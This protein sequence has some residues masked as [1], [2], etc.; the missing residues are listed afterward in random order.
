MGHARCLAMLKLIL[1]LF[2]LVCVFSAYFINTFSYM[3]KYHIGVYQVVKKTKYLKTNLY[4]EVAVTFQDFDDI[5]CGKNME[6]EAKD[7]CAHRENFED[8]GILYFTFST[9]AHFLVFYS[10]F[11]MLGIFCKGSSLGVVKA[12][13]VHYLYPVLHASALAMYL[14]VCRIFV[15]SPPDGYSALT[16]GPEIEE[17]LIVMIVAQVISILSAGVFAVSKK[18][19]RR[20]TRIRPNSKKPKEI[21]RKRTSNDD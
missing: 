1:D 16:Y 11:G 21:L 13:V 20:E 10:I 5:M 2:F 15:L 18:A 9:L 8:A 7:V 19:L 17:G 6:P 14:G 12:D 3:S 4:K